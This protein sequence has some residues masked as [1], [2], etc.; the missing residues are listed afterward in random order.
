MIGPDGVDGRKFRSIGSVA[1][2]NL[3]D[4]E[5]EA[6]LPGRPNVVATVAL[7]LLAWPAAYVGL[8]IFHTAWATF[9]LYHGLCIA[10]AAYH[11]RVYGPPKNRTVPLLD[12]VQLTVTGLIGCL[13]S[14][15]IIRRFGVVVGLI[16]PSLVRHTMNMLYHGSGM[17]SY[18]PLCAYFAI[19]NPIVEEHFWRGA[20]YQRLQDSGV[21]S[22]GALVAS[23]LLFGSWHWLI[24][25][26]LFPPAMALV[27]VAGI[28][29][30]GVFFAQTYDRLHSLSAVALVHSL[31]GDLP[32]IIAFAYAMGAWR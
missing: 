30:A 14:I 22:R 25:R 17:V 3:P 19:V 20:I 12:W 15:F 11:R 24:I 6:P 7:A 32:G 28:M 31:A 21:A 8:Y 23:C 10:G 29:V 18:L 13:A 9:V 2:L 27:V 26:L 1:T 4:A 16:D 5:G